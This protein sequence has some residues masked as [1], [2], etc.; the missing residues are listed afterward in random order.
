MKS[1]M[2]KTT[3]REIKQTFGRFFAIFA[4]IA[5]GVGFFSGVRITTPAMVHTVD[6]FL[7]ENQFYDYRLISTLGWE[8]EDVESFLN[9]D[10]VRY[11]EGAYTADILYINE[12]A[13]EL[14]L[15]THSMPDNINGIELVKGHFPENDNECVVDSVMN[16]RPEIGEHIYVAET[17]E[18]DTLDTI[19]Y[20]E[21]T[22]TGWADSSYYVNFERGTT[23]IG[24]GTVD[25]FVYV[26]KGFFDSDIYTEIFVRFDEDY[27]IYSKAYKN[28]M[29]DKKETW[30]TYVEQQADNRYDRVIAD[31]E[32]KIA[33]GENEL[34]DKREEGQEE[35]DDAKIKLEDGKTELEDSEKKLADAKNDLDDAKREIDDN[36]SKLA[37]AKKELADA[38]KKLD[39]V[40]KQLDNAKSTLVQSKKQLD[41]MDKQLSSGEDQIK[42]G[43]EKIDAAYKELENNDKELTAQETALAAKEAEYKAQLEQIGDMFDMLSAEQQEALNSAGREIE[44]GKNALKEARAKLEAGRGELTANQAALD[45]QKY[46]LSEG[47][48][49]YQKGLIQYEEGVKDYE[50]GVVQYESGK[51]DYENGLEE[52]KDGKSKLEDGEKK[53]RDGLA[54]YNKGLSEYSDGVSDYEDGLN[55]YEDG[56][57]EFNEK[58]ADAEGKIADAKKEL[59]DVEEPDTYL[60]E[61]NT[62]IG[63]ACFENDSEIVAQVAKVFPVF[64]VLVAAL[65]CITTMGRMVEE[66]RTQIGVYKALGY[67]EGTIM[68]KFMFYSGSAALLGCVVGYC[69]GIILFPKVIWTTYRMMYHALPMNYI[70]DWK[71]A[72]LSLAAALICSIGTT[73]I[74]CHYELSETAAGLMRPKAPKAG[75]RVFLEYVP[76]IWNHLKFLHKVSIRNIFR[77]KGR[78]F[79]MIVGIG[80]CTALL[81]TGF[82]IRDSIAD[83]AYMQYD[84][85]Q[86]A[87][88]SM[89]YK[90]EDDNVIP[91]SLR[92]ILDDVSQEYLLLN[93][94]SWDILAGDAVK[95][96]SLVVPENYD[97]IDH[98]MHFRTPDGEPLSVPGKDEVYIC[99]GIAERYEISTGD[100]VTLRDSDMREIRVKVTGIFENHVYNY[101]FIAPET[102]EEQLSERLEYNTAYINFQ[103]GAD[104]Y[105][106]SAGIAK[107]S[108]M[109]SVSVFADVKERMAKMMSSLNYI[110]LVVIAS[111]AGL[112]FIVLYNLT[113]IN[114]TERI[115]EIATIKVLGFFRNETSAYVFREN[116][117]LTMFGVIIGLFLG[118]LLHRYV[119]AQIVV[120]MVCFRTQILPI[121]FVYST[122][123]TFVFTFVVNMFMEAK[124]EKINMAESLKSVE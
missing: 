38:K 64:F 33:D 122:V 1:M 99:E 7:Q 36:S 40:K 3:L 15:K 58:I 101:V 111:A 78:F 80:G 95:E 73:W 116:L 83:F 47:R 5:L 91:E 23:S 68:G 86:T 18:E 103:E 53:Y 89:T 49:E 62:N 2:R 82:G 22:V 32:E 8:E 37:D 113:N 20:R 118:I 90:T 120:D 28:Y 46:T 21:L 43:Q 16:G 112:A 11:A 19:K 88:A 98:Y 77:Y 110:V 44:A 94:S 42:Q 108:H 12:D 87:D 66:Q 54:E 79:M 39:K 72:G 30:E 70:I 57:K 67:S 96:I 45:T 106:Q 63:Y 71:L 48:K 100:E 24:T 97:T 119:M 6:T 59:D 124:L 105:L 51:A 17:N 85:I 121:S 109:T 29:S 117:V 92:G 4:I 27:E 52:Y 61:R 56:V 60:L 107:D 50:K 9:R 123:L 31:A 55:D 69:G 81:V 26:P 41:D 76:G 102:M 34:A 75:K 13:D 74:T 93:E 114:I 25:G 84:E 14:V 35:L 104:I 10:D 65:V 115:R